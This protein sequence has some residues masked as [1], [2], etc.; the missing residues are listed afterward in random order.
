MRDR[1]A[2]DGLFEALASVAKA[3]GHGRRAE[4]VEIL[5]QGQRSVEEIAEAIGQSVPNT[6]HHLR[7]LASSGLLSSRRAGTRIFYS[8]SSDRVAD[9]W[10]AIRELAAEQV[11]AVD[12]LARAYLGETH[13]LEPVSQAE[14]AERLQ[15]GDLVVVDVRPESEYEAGHIHGARSIPLDELEERLAEIPRATEV[16]AYCRGPYCVYADEAV[17]VLGRHGYAARRLQDGFPEWRRSG[18]PVE[19]SAGPGR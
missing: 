11:A 19:A 16:V 7:T 17:R 4:I 6:S 14:L 15:R 18:L 10:R 12:R 3:L 8:L 1:R 5:A 13:G 9:L 2:K